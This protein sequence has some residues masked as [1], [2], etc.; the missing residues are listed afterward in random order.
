MSTLLDWT[1]PAKHWD[2]FKAKPC[3]HNCGF[4]NT[5]LRNDAGQP[6]HKV[7]EEKW[8]DERRP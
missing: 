7:C 8:I 3:R 2:K 1:D 5:N 4:R 6:A